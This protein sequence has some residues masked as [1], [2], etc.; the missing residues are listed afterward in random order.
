[1]KPRLKPSPGVLAGGRGA[2]AAASKSVSK[3]RSQ[4]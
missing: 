1:V 4:P 2:S 3:T